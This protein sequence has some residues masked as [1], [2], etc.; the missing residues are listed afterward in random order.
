MPP[1]ARPPDVKLQGSWTADEEQ[2]RANQFLWTHLTMHLT[3]SHPPFHSVM[4]TWI[5]S[6]L[7]LRSWRYRD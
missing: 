2:D 5:S 7:R 1:V 4:S 6:P 3:A